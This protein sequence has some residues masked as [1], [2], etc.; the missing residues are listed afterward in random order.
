MLVQH[1]GNIFVF[2]TD[3]NLEDMETESLVELHQVLQQKKLMENMVEIMQF[4]NFD[5]DGTCPL[6][7]MVSDLFN[8]FLHVFLEVPFGLNNGDLLLLVG[9]L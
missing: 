8:N 2:N 3:V 1:I 4:C 9:H 5:R 7:E 6:D